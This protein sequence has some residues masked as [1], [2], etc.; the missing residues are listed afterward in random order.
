MYIFHQT[1][2]YLAHWN[3]KI[4]LSALMPYIFYH[5][6]Y[7]KSDIQLDNAFILVLKQ[8]IRMPGAVLVL[9]RSHYIT[10]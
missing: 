1:S 3:A 2:Q 7:S 4:L 9:V 6:V 5:E 8:I 10:C